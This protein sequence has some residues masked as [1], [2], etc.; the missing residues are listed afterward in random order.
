MSYIKYTGLDAKQDWLF[1]AQDAHVEEQSA[2]KVIYQDNDTGD[3]WILYGYNFAFDQ[4]GRIDGGTVTNMEYADDKGKVFVFHG[5]FSYDVPANK[6]LFETDTNLELWVVKDADTMKG[7]KKADYLNAGQ[8]DDYVTG[9]RGNDDIRGEDGNDTLLG[10]AGDDR[11][12]GDSHNDTMTGG[13]GRDQFTFFIGD[14]QDVITDFDAKQDG[15][16]A[17][18]DSV[19]SIY[20]LGTDTVI[21]F[22]NGS[23]ITLLDV[24]PGEI[25]EGLFAF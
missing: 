13:K 25:H 12:W 20:K 14:G 15:F 7:S 21:D 10:G 11:I 24:K 4:T 9:G 2:N 6:Q 16:E 17:D 8:S 3:Q 5:D 18:W 19:Q 23:T 1:D 22:G